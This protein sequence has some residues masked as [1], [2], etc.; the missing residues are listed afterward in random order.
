MAKTFNE[1]FEEI[2]TEI[3]TGKKKRGFSRTDFNK[4][5]TAFLNNTEYTSVKAKTKNGALVEEEIMP[6]KAFRKMLEVILKDFGVDKQ[7]AARVLDNYEIKKADCMYEL[8]S[9]LIYEYMNAGK[10]FD[11]IAKPDWNTTLWIDEEAPST[12]KHK[13]PKTDKY[14]EVKKEKHRVTKRKSKCPNWLKS[15]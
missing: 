1:V 12:K 2:R 14:V 15:K 7:E 3:E 13:I 10:K 5:A 8:C 9:E 6:V 4:L 11:F